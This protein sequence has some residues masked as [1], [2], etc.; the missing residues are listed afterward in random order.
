MGP[1]IGFT[2]SDLSLGR[3]E[4][5]ALGTRNIFLTKVQAVGLSVLTL[6]FWLN[7]PAGEALEL[8][9]STVNRSG[10]REEK[11]FCLPELYPFLA[12]LVNVTQTPTQVA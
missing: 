2:W 10:V 9:R 5:L 11:T 7:D 6:I 4:T 8:D 1:S 3:G 12:D